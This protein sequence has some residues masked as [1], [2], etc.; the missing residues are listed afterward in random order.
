MIGILKSG[1][2]VADRSDGSHIH[3]NARPLIL[4]A[5]AMIDSEQKDFLVEEIDFGREIGKTV[6]VL[7]NEND[8]IVFAR[9][10]NRF[11]PTRFVIG[12]EPEPCSSVV[13]ILK[14]TEEQGYILLT[15]F[16]GRKAEPEPWDRNATE[17][18]LAFWSNR[19]LVWGTEPII[20]DTETAE[21][22]W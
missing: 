15:A 8:Q 18:S 11:G 9:R 7:T 13:I 21:C 4:E 10:P 22:P 1:E 14:R 6:C 12:R 2:M 5:L 20:P 19:A 16:I 17:K 3:E